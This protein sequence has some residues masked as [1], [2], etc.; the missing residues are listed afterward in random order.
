M[1][2]YLFYTI[3]DLTYQTPLVAYHCILLFFYHF[4]LSI[5]YGHSLQHTFFQL[6]PV[7]VSR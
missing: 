5:K 2:R 1:V 4:P 3:G 7:Y 6:P